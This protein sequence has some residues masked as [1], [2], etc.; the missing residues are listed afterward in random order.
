MTGQYHQM[1]SI[2]RPLLRT[3]CNTIGLDTSDTLRQSG[4]YRQLG[5]NTIGYDENVH[6]ARNLAYSD[7]LLGAAF[8]RY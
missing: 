2:S 7:Q 3:S 1:K 5:H 8:I 4:Y 6:K